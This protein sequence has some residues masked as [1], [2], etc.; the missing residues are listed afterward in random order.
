MSVY[1]TKYF[2]WSSHINLYDKLYKHLKS[3]ANI[4]SIYKLS[5][6]SINYF[7]I[8]N[9]IIQYNNHIKLI[10]S[11]ILFQNINKFIIY[12]NEYYSKNLK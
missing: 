6:F 9:T 1:P 3:E 11:S 2:L 5:K 10:K 12:Y 4:K 8:F 7:H